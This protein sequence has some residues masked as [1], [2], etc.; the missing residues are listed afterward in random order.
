[1]FFVSDDRL[2]LVCLKLHD[3]ECRYFSIVE[4][5]TKSGC[6]FEPAS[7]G[8][9][10]IP[11]PGSRPAEGAPLQRYRSSNLRMGFT[12][13]C[14][15]LPWDTAPRYLVRDRDAIYGERVR[16]QLKD[17][18]VKEILTAPRSPWQ[19]PYVE[20]LIGSIRRRMPRSHS[21]DQ[22]SLGPQDTTLL[23][24]LLSQEPHSPR[25]DKTH[26]THAQYT[27]PNLVLW[28][29]SQRSAAFTIDTKEE[30]PDTGDRAL[31][32]SQGSEPAV[33]PLANGC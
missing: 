9:P 21:R 4:P 28:S 6:L 11:C 22:R 1:M 32:L 15:S 7:D 14:S 3:G 8:I 17:M 25:T 33:C 10:R 29:R 12:S 5:T 24:R 31:L 2:K 26:Q 13:A 20:R 18:A 23:F 16:R 30:L 19:S 27:L